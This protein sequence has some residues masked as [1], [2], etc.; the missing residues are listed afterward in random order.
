MALSILHEKG[1]IHNFL[2][3][4]PEY[5]AYLIGDLDDFFWHKTIWFADIIDNEIRAI[6]LLYVG[7]DTPS[8]LAFCSQED[9]TPTKDLL[10]AIKPLLPQTFLTH[11]S[12]GLIEVFGEENI[13][14]YYGYNCKMALRNS[15]NEF[16][17]D[18]IRHL[19]FENLDMIKNLYSIAYP[20]NW[21]DK[22]MLGTGQYLGYFDK[23]NLVGIAGIH[24]YSE[25]YKVAALG[26]IATHPNYRGQQISYRLTSQLCY[27]LRKS[28]DHIG[29]NVKSDNEA[30]IKCY[31]KLGFEFIGNYDECMI[32][33]T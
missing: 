9:S 10:K 27:E 25:E 3:D 8:L 16:K 29:L 14:E 7:M 22:R 32:K 13:V 17:N 30:A 6:A 12:S 19:N 4:N 5:N 21:F 11:L 28:V 15:P 23:N 20:N 26:N 24:V 2:I 1:P 33:N 18:N 31:E